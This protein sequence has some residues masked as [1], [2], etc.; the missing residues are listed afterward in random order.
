M[1]HVWLITGASSGFGRSIAEE[2]L[3]SGDAVVAGVRSSGRVQDLKAAYPESFRIVH[4]DVTQPEQIRDGIEAAGSAF[5][6]LDVVV[7]NAGYGLVGALEEVSDEQ[8]ARNIETNL[9]GP[10]RVMRAVLPVLRRQGSGTIV[11]ISA[12]AAF[13]NYAGFA[14]YGGAKAALD[15]ASEAVALE[16][17]PLGIRVIVVSPGPFRTEFISR[18]LDR[19]PVQMDDYRATSGKFGVMLQRMNGK[20]PGD[21]SKA[22]RAIIGAVRSDRPPFRLVLGQYAVKKFRSKL[23]AIGQ[24]LDMWES[25]GAATDFE[26]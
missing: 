7:N 16:V 3:L 6:K 19:A 11:N 26:R 10:L 25:A 20:Q 23:A 14:V 24:E 15:A 17:A 1:A 22:A 21:P 2:V 9:M 13:A 4:M 12:V 18:S 5:G 8:I